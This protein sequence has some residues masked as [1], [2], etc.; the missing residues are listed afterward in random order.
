MREGVGERGFRTIPPPQPF[1]HASL[2]FG[3]GRALLDLPQRVGDLRATR[4]AR[5]RQHRSLG[6]ALA[7]RYLSGLAV[8]V[9]EPGVIRLG[10]VVVV[11]RDPEHGDHR[12]APLARDPPGERHRREGLIDGVQRTSEEP[13]LLAGRDDEYLTRGELIAPRPR[14]GRRDHVGFHAPWHERRRRQREW[15]DRRRHD[16]RSEEHTSE[17]Q[18]RFDLVCRLLLEKKKKKK[19]TTNNETTNKHK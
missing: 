3:V 1:E 14:E 16:A 18:S 9:E 8:L 7:Q 13:R 19:K 4:L 10:E 6:R 17:L 11:P 2:E 5:Q 15:S 12:R